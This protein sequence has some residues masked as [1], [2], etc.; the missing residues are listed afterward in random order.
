[1]IHDIYH[2]SVS[3]G[4]PGVDTDLDSAVILEIRGLTGTHCQSR[5]RLERGRDKQV[6]GLNGTEKVGDLV[7]W[8][9]R[10]L[11]SGID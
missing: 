4:R 1:M 3:A 10:S 6:T 9:K 5:G 7:L 11:G 2:S 8:G